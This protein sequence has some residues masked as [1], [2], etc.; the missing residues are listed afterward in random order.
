MVRLALCFTLGAL[1]AACGESP[2]KGYYRP[3]ERAPIAPTATAPSP[4]ATPP[5]QDPGGAVPDSETVPDPGTSNPSRPYGGGIGSDCGTCSEP[6]NV[7]LG[8]F[9]GG[10]C[11]RACSRLCPDAPGQAKTFCIDDRSA[12]GGICVAKTDSSLGGGCRPGYVPAMRPRFNEPAVT[13][14]VC[15][16]AAEETASCLDE[17]RALIG[18]T[19]P[20]TSPESPVPGHPALLCR[21]P[22][23]VALGD[24]LNG[25]F[26]VED[27][28]FASRPLEVSCRFAQTLVRMS[29]SLSKLG[30]ERLSYRYLYACEAD[31]L[32][33]G[34]SPHG[35]GEAMDIVSV[36]TSTTEFSFSTFQVPYDYSF[37][38]AVIE[39]LSADHVFTNIYTPFCNAEMYPDF[40]HVDIGPG[41]SPIRGLVD[42]QWSIDWAPHCAGYF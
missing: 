36:A 15:V 23:G 37:L 13:A 41:N 34:V 22:E 18:W 1:A 3:R 8:S 35:L 2:N 21:V 9:P 38:Q 32:G 27:G 42:P 40:A 12:T 10:M 19:E 16:P 4:L 30:I 33:N 17:L 5:G 20:W 11:S 6:A 29:E 14:Q 24:Q 31:E 26:L 39:K 7:C 25:V 28:A